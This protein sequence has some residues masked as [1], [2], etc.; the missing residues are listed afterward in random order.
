MTSVYSLKIEMIQKR[1][2]VGRSHRRTATNLTD[3]RLGRL[4]RTVVYS[5]NLFY[6][7]N[8]FFR[9]PQMG[10]EALWVILFYSK[11]SAALAAN[12]GLEGSK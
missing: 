12:R 7:G 3:S 9:P 11:L 4:Y 8:S 6:R 1:A 5:C 10:G 2:S